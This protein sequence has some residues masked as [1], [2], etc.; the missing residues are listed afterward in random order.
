MLALT[1]KTGY[2]L[3]AMSYLAGLDEGKVASAR[4]MAEKLALPLSLLTNVLKEL[5]ADGFVRSARGVAGGYCLARDPEQINLAD[6]LSALEG[7]IRSAHCVSGRHGDDEECDCDIM[8][9]CPV[10]DPVHR[11]H[12]RLS[13]SLR[14]MT[15]ADIARPVS[16]T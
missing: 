15:L 10:F 16:A 13:D 12:R 9:D 8:D 3:V 4:A 2:G 11:V 7:P 14:K 5:A 1:R 6:L